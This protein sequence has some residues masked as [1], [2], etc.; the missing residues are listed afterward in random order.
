MQFIYCPAKI[1]HLQTAHDQDNVL[2]FDIPMQDFISMH[3][4]DGL[5]KVLDDKGRCFFVEVFVVGHKGIELT[6]TS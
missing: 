4:V 5:E 2:W 3:V 6:I 1:T